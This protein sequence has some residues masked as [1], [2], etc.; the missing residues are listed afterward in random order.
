EG[1]ASRRND[2]AMMLDEIREVD[3]REAGSIAYMLANGQGKGRAGT[4]G[5][6]RTRKQWRLLFFSTGELSLTEHAAK[7][8]E[9]TFA[10]MEVRMIQIPS[11]SGKFGVFEELHGFDSGKALA[12]HLEWATSCYYGSPFREWLKALTA[13]LNGLTAQAKSLMK[14][15]A[16]ALTPKDAGNQVG[17]AV[18]RF[19]LVAMA[20]ELATRLG[21]T[22]WPEG[23]AL[24]ATR[25]CLNAW[26]KDRGHTANQ[27]DIAALE[28]VRSFF[29]ANQY[30][31]FA[32]WYDE[33]NRP[34]NMVGWRRVEKGSTAQGTEAVT[35]FYVMPS[36][37]KEICRGFDPRK[38]AR[39][40]ADRGYLLPSTDGK[41]Q[42]TIRPPEMNPRR[43]YVFNSEVPG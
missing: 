26:L 17:R 19:A 16:A 4:D 30:S 39:L 9:R 38:V 10:G 29:T 31:R 13:D 20:G 36:G 5:E 3:G 2:A 35:T 1:C 15:Y 27:E 34:G 24:R 32:D 14:E 18:N 41:L 37:W 21:I 6:L 43:L 7:A 25:V 42:T 23:E 12:E 22:G 11:D 40:C 33:R 8:G 28:Q